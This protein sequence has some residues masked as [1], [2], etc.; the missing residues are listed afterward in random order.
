MPCLT[1]MANEPSN[2]P[3]G[4][5]ITVEVAP[6]DYDKFQRAMQKVYAY[7]PIKP[8]FI[9]LDL[10]IENVDY[11]LNGDGWALRPNGDYPNAIMGVISYPIK[12]DSLNNG[13]NYDDILECPFDIDFDLGD[14][15]IEASREGLGYDDRTKQHIRKRLDKVIEECGIVI[16]DKIKESKNLWE[17]R[18]AYFTLRDNVPLSAFRVVDW[19][20]VEYNGIRLFPA[21]AGNVML[22]RLVNTERVKV[23]RFKQGRYSYK[24]GKYKITHS[25]VTKVSASKKILFYINDNGKSFIRKAS[26]KRGLEDKTENDVFVFT[27]KDDDAKQ[28]LFDELGLDESYFGKVTELEEPPKDNGGS[29]GSGVVKKTRVMKFNRDNDSHRKNEYWEDTSVTL[30]NAKD[31]MYVETCRY[32]IKYKGGTYNPER[33]S[34]LI[35]KMKK[36]GIFSPKIVGV[37]KIDLKKAKDIPNFLDWALDKVQD[38]VYNYSDKQL[39]NDRQEL[40]EVFNSWS[41]NL[42]EEDFRKISKGLSKDHFISILIDLI[43]EMKKEVGSLRVKESLRSI[44]CSFGIKTETDKKVVKYDLVKE[45]ERIYEV[46][47]MLKIVGKNLDKKDVNV[48][49]DYINLIDKGENNG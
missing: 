44:A 41:Q 16:Q 37:K 34:R 22:T 40:S 15:D 2:E 8:N 6:G 46:Y 9:G 21:D 17:A 35:E 20:K 23:V 7:F 38:P 49:I 42:Y 28:E 19:S 48:A 30:E 31:I 32:D 4:I 3:T 1:E 27:F 10:Q 45:R 39:S 47:P 13:R 25:N 14:L 43:D 26:Y 12:C 24:M 29:N 11:V 18:C 33:L 36:N 5:K